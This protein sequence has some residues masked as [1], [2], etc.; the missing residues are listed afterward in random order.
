MCI[1]VYLYMFIYR[2]SSTYEKGTPKVSIVNSF[3]EKIITGYAYVEVNELVTNVGIYYDKR[4][5]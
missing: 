4:Q 1:F 3:L 2:C 5:H